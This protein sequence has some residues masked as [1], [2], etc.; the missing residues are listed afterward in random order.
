MPASVLALGISLALS[1]NVPHVDRTLAADVTTTGSRAGIEYV[2]G[3]QKVSFSKS[4]L[5]KWQEV[6]ERHD[7]QIAIESTHWGSFVGRFENVV[8]AEL[9]QRVNREVN[10]A[11][12]VKDSANWGVHDFWATPQ[13]LFERG[14]DC[15][16][17]AIAKYLVLR[18]LGVRPSNMQIAVSR[19]HAVLIVKTE[20]GPVVLDN[21]HSQI[22]PLDV[23]FAKRI[24]FVVNDHSWAV[25]VGRDSYQLAS[26]LDLPSPPYPPDALP[27]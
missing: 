18:E 8:A 22:R 21:N 16:D 14:G 1:V 25:N 13:E 20:R 2:T 23:R 3:I 17:Y 26:R 9:L 12:Y 27:L 5:A 19:T 11:R 4:T 24:V 6:V 10:R 7:R 15:E